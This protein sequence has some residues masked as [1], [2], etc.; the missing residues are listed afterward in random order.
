MST[1]TSNSN[2]DNDEEN[3]DSDDSQHHGHWPPNE[4]PSS[5]SASDLESSSSGHVSG[6][7]T[8]VDSGSVALLPGNSSRDVEGF[9][10]FWVG[11]IAGLVQQIG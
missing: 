8:T 2:S 4:S 1:Q 3:E 5:S 6:E 9:I 7:G 11:M 10:M